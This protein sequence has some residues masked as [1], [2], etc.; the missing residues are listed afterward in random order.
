M[1]KWNDDFKATA[2]FTCANDTTHVENVTAEV[3]SAVTTPAACETTGVRTYT[4]KVTFEGKE[5]TS[6]KTET[7]AATGHAYGEPVWKWTDDFKATATFTCTNDATH[8]ENVTAE[9][10]S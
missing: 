5:Y 8:V 2:T 7:I 3:T 10:T 6:S 1:W 9:V 4:A